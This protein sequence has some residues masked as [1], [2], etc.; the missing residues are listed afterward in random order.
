MPNPKKPKSK[1]TAY[2]GPRNARAP[3]NVIRRMIVQG[4]CEENIKEIIHNTDEG[5]GFVLTSATAYS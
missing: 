5:R 4:E 1:L 2:H 3:Q